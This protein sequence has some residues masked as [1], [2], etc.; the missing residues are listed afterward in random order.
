VRGKNPDVYAR[1]EA[2][3]AKATAALEATPPD[4]R[5]AN[6]ALAALTQAARDYAAASS[7]KAASQLNG[8]AALITMLGQVKDS[9]AEGKTDQAADLMGSFIELWPVVEGQVKARSDEVYTRVESEMMRADGFLLSKTDSSADAAKTVALMLG[10]LNGIRGT[11][12]YSAWDAGFILL[13]EGLE[14]LLVLAALLAMLRKAGSAQGPR[15][16]WAGAGTGFALS[17][18]LAVILGLLI[19][20]AATGAARESVEGWVG[21]ASVVLML[22]VGA[23]LHRRSSLQAWNGFVKNRMGSAIAAGGTWSLFSLA[24]LAVLREGAETVVFYIGIA[25]AIGLGQLL[26][27]V[28][29]SAAILVAIGFLLIRFSVRLPLHY[30]FLVAT[31]LIY[32]LA[33]KIT[34]ESIHALQVAGAIPARYA[35]SLPTLGF[36]G[37]SATW[38]TTLLQAIVFVLVA[39]EIIVTEARNARQRRK[40]AA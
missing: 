17:V 1:V 7:G 2:S 10:Q 23:W 26:L 18:V 3:S 38:E 24:L 14:A 28:A 21:L 37:M 25:S 34:G 8:V 19:T 36:F 30:V 16:V 20:A 4:L 31:V 11:G 12:G 33:F 35:D 13:R 40:S 9:I 15:W 39:T 29:V 6:D 32:Y 22:S 5:R 27:G